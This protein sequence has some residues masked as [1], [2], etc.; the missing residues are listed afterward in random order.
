VLKVR[1]CASNDPFVGVTEHYFSSDKAVL[2]LI[3]YATSQRKLDVSL[4]QGWKIDQTLYGAADWEKKSIATNSA[5]VLS[6]SRSA[7]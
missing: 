7:K 6:I 4:A 5:V 1:V 3:N 2:A